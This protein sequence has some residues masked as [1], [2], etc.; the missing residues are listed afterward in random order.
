MI[1]LLVN[2]EIVDSKNVDFKSI[3]NSTNDMFF[4]D[5]VNSRVKDAEDYKIIFSHKNNILRVHTYVHYFDRVNN[6]FSN[7]RYKSANSM[8][9]NLHRLIL[10]YEIEKRMNKLN[11]INAQ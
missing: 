10:K 3:E 11:K 6:K 5:I 9:K 8:N 1:Y 7:I 4:Q 2:N